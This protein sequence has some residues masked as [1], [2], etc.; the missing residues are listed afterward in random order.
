VKTEMKPQVLI[1]DLTFD[2]LICVGLDGVFAKYADQDWVKIGSIPAVEV[3]PIRGAPISLLNAAR[4]VR[5]RSLKITLNQ[6]EQVWMDGLSSSDENDNYDMYYSGHGSN[7]IDP[8]EGYWGRVT[9]TF[10][11]QC[12]FQPKRLI[13]DKAFISDALATVDVHEDVILFHIHPF[14][15]PHL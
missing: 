4:L 14:L 15:F 9:H 12:D 10:H 7:A 5:T 8:V 11:F 13:K 6:E 3:L 1:Q 2:H